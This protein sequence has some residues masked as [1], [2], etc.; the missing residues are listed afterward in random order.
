MQWPDR[1]Y[2]KSSAS[3]AADTA[4]TCYDLPM[5]SARTPVSF[6]ATDQPDAARAFFSDVIGLD[7]REASPFA[8]VFVDGDHVLRVQIVEKMQPAPYTVHGWQV[9]D[10][11]LEIER[12]TA[13]GV[14]FQRFA[15]LPQDALGI[16]TTPDGSKIAWF[17]DPS[18]NVLSLTQHASP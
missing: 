12:L 15:Q 18:G 10:I 7:L 5:Q 2:A 6:I 13:Y 9:T 4:L 16:W 1:P 17:S 3:I 11:A 8:L 14:S